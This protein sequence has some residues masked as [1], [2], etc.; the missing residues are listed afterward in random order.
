M[1]LPPVG[2]S[3]AT[4]A[5]ALQRTVG[6]AAT[7]RILA[8]QIQRKLP[9]GLAP[10]TPVVHHEEGG[11]V[12]GYQIVK[13]I[14]GN[15][16]IKGPDDKEYKGI[17]G[18]NADWGVAADKT[19]SRAEWE[20]VR[21]AR[22][23]GAE[24]EKLRKEL[25]VGE[26]YLS[27]DYRRINPLLAALEK[28]G[29]TS[30]QVRDKAF[31]YSAKKAT[32]LADMKA[33]A[34]ARKY[35]DEGG[36]EAWTEAEVDDVYRMLRTI[37]DVWDKFETPKG[38]GGKQYTRVFRGDSK[39]LYDSFPKINPSIP[40]NGYKEG[41]NAASV[42]VSMPGMLSTTYG[43]PKE[44]NYVKGKTV[45]WDIALSEVNAGKG[46]GANNQSEKELTF[47]IGTVLKIHT[48]LVRQKDKTAEAD[49]YGSDAEVVLKATI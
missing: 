42:D 1:G 21:A 33:I 35:T 18:G 34:L 13:A 40:E 48:I 4:H 6:N 47:P 16:V 43:D 14:I 41:N 17:S 25:I 22:E 30:E 20:K 2:Q 44:H 45:V 11:D 19:T 10:G 5:L 32:I 3:A 9:K 7:R 26:N 38:A 29:Y 49:A 31:D 8:S 39:F 23:A 46:L 27:A 28:S 24:A 36:A 37:L 12:E 15:Y